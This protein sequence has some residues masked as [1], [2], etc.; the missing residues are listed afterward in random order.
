M[1]PFLVYVVMA[2]VLPAAAIGQNAPTS[3]D[4]APSPPPL[5]PAQPSPGLSSDN[6]PPPA[7][8]A[9]SPGE[10]EKPPPEIGLMVSESAF[11]ILT[12]GATSLIP[13]FLLLRNSA[14]LTGGDPTIG[15]LLYVLVF[16][17]VPLAV[18]QTE[19]SLANGSA[20]YFSESWPASLSGLAT[21][22]AVIGL[23]MAINGGLSTGNGSGEAVLLA[24]TTVFVPLVEMAVINLTKVQRN[25]VPF[26]GFGAAR[27]T[28]QGPS[29]GVPTPVPL[30]SPGS[31][32][33]EGLSLPLASGVF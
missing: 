28:P 30:F 33:L 11:G 12:A 4:P 23:Y 9:Q 14:S 8:Y 2:A 20:Y 16:S 26:G 1:R 19:L 27:F 31:L 25:K 10:N 3:A 22:A 13:Y 32:Q 6:E 18:S 5:V 24:G 29:F 15:N 21:Q 7:A 17:A